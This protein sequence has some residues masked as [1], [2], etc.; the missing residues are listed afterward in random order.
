M[1]LKVTFAPKI[2]VGKAGSGMHIHTKI[3]DKQGVN[4]YVDAEGQLTD[5]ARKAVAGM[6]S[7]AASL[8]AFGNMNPTSYLR[9]VPHQEAPTT[10]CWG[11]R[12][13]SA[14]VRVPLG[15]SAKVDMSSLVNPLEQPQ[16]KRY[17]NKQTIEFRASDGSA[18]AYLLLAGITTA[19]RRGFELPNALELAKQTYVSVNI[20]KDEFASSVEHLDSLPTSCVA[21]AERLRQ[22]RAAY[23]AMGVFSPAA[24]DGVIRQLEAFEDADLRAKAQADPQFLM[25]L[26]E[27]HLYC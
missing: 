15:W 12:N 6:M 19:V 17:T 10:V 22:D 11:D 16:T 7:L 14:L 23:E 24:I 9:L 4:Q 3:V 1:G 8:T 21:S 25:E 27:R 20:H 26:V 2:I 5:T 13:R 18:N